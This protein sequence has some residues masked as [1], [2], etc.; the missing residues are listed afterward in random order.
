M[1]ILLLLDHPNGIWV[2]SSHTTNPHNP[3]PPNP[4][5]API[6]AYQTNKPEQLR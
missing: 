6:L 1:R 3:P 4:L 2:I 5:L